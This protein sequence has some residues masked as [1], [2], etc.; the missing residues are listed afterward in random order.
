MGDRDVLATA[1]VTDEQLAAMVSSHLGAPDVEVLESTADIAPY[2]LEALTTA[3]RYRVHGVARHTGG[4][5]PFQFYVKVVQ[6]WERSP[7]FA[8]VP[9]EVREAALAGLPWKR[10]PQVYRSDLPDLMPAGLTMP[11][12]YGVFDVDELSAAIWLELVDAVDIRW[13]VERFRSAAY[14]LGRL[15]ASSRV[16]PVAS[17]GDIGSV[18][19]QYAFGRLA[20]QVLPPLRGEDIWNHPLIAATFDDDLRKGLTAAAESL[21]DYLDE[22]DA[23]PVGTIHGD[24]CTRNLLVTRDDGFVVIDFGFWGR[25]PLGFDL[26]QLLMGEAQM[27]ER[28]AAELAALEEACLPAYRQG[29]LDEGIKVSEN[30]LRRAHALLMLEFAGLSAI[31][32]EHL[33]GPPTAERLRIAGERA[34]SARFI[35]DLGAAT[36]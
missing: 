22:L 15:A 27:G 6:S 29:L 11:R 26:T 19:R 34:A 13:D 1:D 20:H 28:P 7:I 30:E 35:L 10:E 32:F 25:G 17:I 5:A 23:F 18:P 31:P 14:L 3:G 24:A 36:S 16:A 2:D 12:C 4:E 8:F 21:P 33:D 9:E